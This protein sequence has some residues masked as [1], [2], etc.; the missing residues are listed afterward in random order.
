MWQSRHRPSWPKDN[1][2]ESFAFICS[3]LL[4]LPWANLVAH[5]IRSAARARQLLCVLG[6]SSESLVRCVVVIATGVV[7]R[8]IARYGQDNQGRRANDI[9]WR[10]SLQA[11]SHH[12]RGAIPLEAW[13]LKASPADIRQSMCPLEVQSSERTFFSPQ[14]MPDEH[15]PMPLPCRWPALITLPTFAKFQLVWRRLCDV[16]LLPSC[17][18]EHTL[19]AVCVLPR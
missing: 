6:A 16:V 7:L 1:V 10:T 17:L 3:M 11:V 18:V 12:T 5:I 4:L 19:T 8:S 15:P 13:L 14:T 2:D 9:V